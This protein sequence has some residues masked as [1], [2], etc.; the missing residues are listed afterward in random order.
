VKT[1]LR[2]EWQP[3]ARRMAIS[4]AKVDRLWVQPSAIAF[5]RSRTLVRYC[6]VLTYSRGYEIIGGG[7]HRDIA[8]AYSKNSSAHNTSASLRLYLEGCGVPPARVW[9]GPLVRAIAWMLR[10]L[11][12]SETRFIFRRIVIS[13]EAL[14]KLTNE[15]IIIFWVRKG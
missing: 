3:L 9:Y 2:V 11:G 15:K 12:T 13:I 14:R 6:G 7:K 1:A 4:S 10:R 5:S 8:Q